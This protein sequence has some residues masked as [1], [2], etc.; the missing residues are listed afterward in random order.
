MS[1]RAVVTV[2]GDGET[3]HIYKHWD[4]YPSNI[5]DCLDA[6]VAT[7]WTLPRFEASDFAAA[8]I[9]ANKTSGGDVYI[10]R[11]PRH[12]GDLDYRYEVTCKGGAIRVNVYRRTWTPDGPQRDG[13]AR[14]GLSL[15]ELRKVEI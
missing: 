2:T 6:T 1:T 7:A 5:A 13:E 14:K 4:G 15:I 9:A 8:F 11:G 3:F 12:H 10:S